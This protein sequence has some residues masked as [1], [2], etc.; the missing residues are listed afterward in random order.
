MFLS[1]CWGWIGLTARTGFAKMTATARHPG[2]LDRSAPYS[3]AGQPSPSHPPSL[4]QS[5]P[6]LTVKQPGQSPHHQRRSW[7]SRTFLR[8]ASATTSDASS[9]RSNKTVRRRR[10]VSD[11]ALHLVNGGAGRRDNLKDEDLQSLVRLCGK[12]KLYLPQGY[13][14]GE[15]VLPTCLRAT[16]QYLVQHGR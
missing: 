12:S 16:A 15:L 9:T 2:A 4:P 1:T 10:S 3:L 7:F 11:L 8:Q 14:P 6:P 13:A 5:S